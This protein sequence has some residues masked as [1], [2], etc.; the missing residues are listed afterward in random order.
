M[1]R[2]MMKWIDETIAAEQKQGFLVLS[3]PAIQKMGITVKELISS[4]DLQAQAMKI[5]AN[6][7]PDAAASVSMMDLSLEAEAFGSKAIFFDDEVPTV[8]GSIVNT[9]EEAEAL[10][11]PE[12]GAGRTQIYI[13]AIEKAVQ[14][15]EDRPVF[16]GV[17]GPFSL[18]GR[19]MDVSEAMMYCYDEP[20]MVHIV[21]EK[22]TE[23]LIK[24]INAYKAIGANGVLMAEPLAGLLSPGLEEE[25]STPYVK[26]IVEAT[27]SDDF[28]VCYHNCGNAA[29]YQV[30]SI[31]TNG[32]RVFHFGNAIEMT[33]VVKDIPA[34]KLVMG[35]VDPSTQFRNGTPA[36]VKAATMDLMEKLS[37]YPNFVVSSGCDIPP[38]SSWDNIL[39][40]FDGVKEF[41]NK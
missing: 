30:K 4:S 20:D 7:T 27:Q 22:A 21:L 31:A 36:S 10:E 8:L 3:F 2:N 16:A 38:L 40:F 18:A 39:A 29:Q 6:L 32:C 24:Y 28:I 14:L 17:I 11:I 25:F 5:V 1:K 12:I 35:N 33:E 41:Y 9:E 23:F 15:I 34:D 26:K 37:D 19:L 13:D